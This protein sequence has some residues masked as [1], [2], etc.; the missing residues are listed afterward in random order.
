M[1]PVQKNST[2]NGKIF[3]FTPRD[4]TRVRTLIYQK[5]GIALAESK[6]EMVYSR[7]ARRLRAKGLNTFEE[8]LNVLESGSDNDEWVAFTNALTTTKTTVL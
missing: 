7:L 5:A 1:K 4:F 6:Q 8:Y 2:D 3:E